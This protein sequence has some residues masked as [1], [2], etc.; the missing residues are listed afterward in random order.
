MIYL[1]IKKHCTYNTKYI[2]LCIKCLCYAASINFYSSDTESIW[3]FNCVPE[4][5]NI[6]FW[7]DCMGFDGKIGPHTFLNRILI[8]RSIHDIA[9]KKIHVSFILANHAH[10]YLSILYLGFISLLLQSSGIISTSFI[11]S[12]PSWPTGTSVSAINPDNGSPIIPTLP[13]K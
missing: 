13:E 12:W 4:K 1:A 9:G 5:T 6:G 2:F 3:C 8:N 7:K 11:S 10:I